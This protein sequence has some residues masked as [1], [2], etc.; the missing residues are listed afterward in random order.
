VPQKSTAKPVLHPNLRLAWGGHHL[1]GPG[2]A[3]LLEGIAVTGS[4]AQAASRMKMSYMKAWLLIQHLEKRIRTP[5]VQKSR[6]GNK[7]GGAALTPAGRA[8]LAAYRAIEADCQRAAKKHLKR[9]A[10]CIEAH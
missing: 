1:F 10:K 3:D 4:I 6:G 8:L 5:L 2:K 7:G 9:I